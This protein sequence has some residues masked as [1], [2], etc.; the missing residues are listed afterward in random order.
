MHS[1]ARARL[2]MLVPST[3]NYTLAQNSVLVRYS[4]VRFVYYVN[5]G[6][7]APCR[8]EP[9]PLGPVAGVGLVYPARPSSRSRNFRTRIIKRGR[10]VMRVRK[11]REREEG[12]AR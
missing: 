2:Y 4:T 11:L 1:N 9:N 8:T 6:R 10:E 3:L 7:T 5:G 12:L